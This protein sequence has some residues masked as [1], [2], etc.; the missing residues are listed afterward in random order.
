MSARGDRVRA[1]PQPRFWLWVVG[2]FLAVYVAEAVLE[3]CAHA[4]GVL[5]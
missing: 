5:T 3:W 2:V 1:M 4:F